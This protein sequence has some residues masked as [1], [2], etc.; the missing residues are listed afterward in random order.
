MAPL[1]LAYGCAATPRGPTDSW[2]RSL[3]TAF[4]IKLAM[5]HPVVIFWGPGFL[6]LYNEADAALR[7]PEKHPLILGRPAL[8]AWPEAYPFCEPDLKQV[9]AG[10]EATWQEN[11]LI[12]IRRHGRFD[13]AYWTYSLDRKSTRLNSS[14]S[15]ATRMPPSA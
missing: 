6:C 12:P 1:I 10:G 7:G 14:H 2:P 13:E 11:R 4:D 9:M 5:R 3:K 15:C 8:E